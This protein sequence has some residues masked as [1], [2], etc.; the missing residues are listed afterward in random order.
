MVRKKVPRPLIFK[1]SK[2]ATHP[3]F[4]CP[5]GNLTSPIEVCLLSG[6][7]PSCGGEATHRL[8]SLCVDV[9][10]RVAF[11]AFH[12]GLPFGTSCLRACRSKCQ[13]RVFSHQR[14][15]RSWPLLAY[16]HT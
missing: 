5:L 11:F 2:N 7:V 16:T 13:P 9:K 3:G 12:R 15:T 14:R 4:F 10:A 6:V 8:C 1:E